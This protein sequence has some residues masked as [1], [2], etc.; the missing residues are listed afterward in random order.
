MFNDFLFNPAVAGIH[1]YYQVTSNHRFQWV[2]I[3]DPPMTNTLSINGPHG[4]LPMGF[5]ATLYNDVTG[6]TS[7]TGLSG[8]Y[9]Y[10]VEI[11]RDI[12]VSMG[13]SMG[14]IQYKMD[15]T[16]MIIKN[17]DDQ[18]IQPIVYSTYVPDASVGVYAYAEEWYAGF[19]VA[20]LFNNKL[21]IY[22]QKTGLEQTQKPLLPHR[23]IYYEIN[24]DYKIRSSALVAGTSPRN[25]PV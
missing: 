23:R 10:N 21:R 1:D 12:N 9:A 17:P 24:R 18:A 22:D 15:G 14:L 2:G 13:L 5:G 8:A 6:P 20:Q 19:S 4:K 16:Q 11:N 25:N 3:T 7:R